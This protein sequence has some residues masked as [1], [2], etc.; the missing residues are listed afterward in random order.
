MT[1]LAAGERPSGEELFD[2]LEAFAAETPDEVGIRLWT[3]LRGTIVELSRARILELAQRGAAAY[4]ARG[5]GSGDRVLID[6]PTSEALLAALLGAF[7]AG[8]WPACVAPLSHRAGAA[9]EAEWGALVERLQPALIV[10]LEELPAVELPLMAASELLEADPAG[11]GA[12]VPAAEMKYVQ[13][14]SGSTGTPKALVLGM[15]GI[16][17]NILGMLH[18]IPLGREDRLVSWLPCYHD[19]GLF[20]TVLL[21][22]VG[23]LTLSLMDPALFARNPLVWLRQV[24]EA[25]GTATVAPPSAY[26]AMLEFQKRRP[27]P[28]LDLSDCRVWLCGAEQ[29]TPE[30]ERSFAE[31]LADARAQ[32]DR[33]YPVYGM[34]EIT[35]AATMPPSARP[36]RV[37]TVDGLGWVSVGSPLI[38]QRMRVVDEAGEGLPDRCLGRDLLASPC[39]YRPRRDRGAPTPRRGGGL[40]TR[41]PRLP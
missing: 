16:V 19:M 33:L 2:R 36:P 4:R 25:R 10:S 3:D 32:V 9:A 12:R 23:R 34:S 24:H 15:E 8:V 28:D 18:A 27:V 13:F 17:H 1:D 30:L 11:C 29:V 20:G 39:P 40:G 21:S 41:A 6:L 14:S 37:E 26:K 31:G 7:H 22:L 38:G 35:L 5:L